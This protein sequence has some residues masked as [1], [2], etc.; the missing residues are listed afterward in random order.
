MLFYCKLSLIVIHPMLQSPMG[1]FEVHAL[2]CSE[3]NKIISDNRVAVIRAE[4]NNG[5]QI[6][7]SCGK[8]DQ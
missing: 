5:I 4:T 1:P 6:N 8:D 7:V 2:P 3:C